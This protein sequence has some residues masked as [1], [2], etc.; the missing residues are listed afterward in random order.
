MVDKC[1]SLKSKVFGGAHAIGQTAQFRIC[2]GG[3]RLREEVHE[4]RI[5]SRRLVLDGLDN[6]G[7]AQFW[8]DRTLS[9]SHWLALGSC[10]VRR[11]GVAGV[12]S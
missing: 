9:E 8:Y 1:S 3:P 4:G 12:I 11:E 6:F 2:L 5:P 7:L 10:V